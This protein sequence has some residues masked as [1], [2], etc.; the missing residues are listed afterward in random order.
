MRLI[1]NLILSIS[2]LTKIIYMKTLY[3]AFLFFGCYLISY[4]QASKLINP[5]KN[6]TL[7]AP[8]NYTGSEVSTN[9]EIDMTDVGAFLK[10]DLE[11][12][13]GETRYDLQTNGS[14]NNRFT[15]TSDG[16]MYAVWTMGFQETAFPDRGTGYNSFDGSDWGD[17]PTARLEQDA[18][19]GWPNYSRT[20]SGA[21]FIINHVFTDGEYRLHYLRRDSDTEDWTEGDV[22]TNTPSG[23]LWPNSTIGGA[24]GET[25]HVIAICTPETLGGIVYQGVE[26]HLLYYRSQD[27]GKTWDIVDGVLPGL[28][29]L[30]MVDL[31]RADAYDMDSNGD[32]ISMVLL[33]HW[34][35]VILVKSTD[36]GD[37]WTKTIV[38]DFPVD[39]YIT[40]TGY[41]LES[42]P[43]DSLTYPAIGSMFTSDGTGSVLVDNEGMSHVF[44]G[45]MYVTDA[46]TFDGTWSY[47]PGTTGIAYWNETFPSDSTAFIANVDDAN[48]NGVI[49]LNGELAPYGNA[50]LTSHTSPG[51]DAD[52]NIYLAYTAVVEGDEYIDPQDGQQ[53]RQTYLT[54]SLDGGETWSF[55]P[56]NIINAET[57]GDEAVARLT[58]AV[59]PHMAKLVDDQI[60]IMYQADF[61]PGLSIAGDGDPYAENIIKYVAIDVDDLIVSNNEVAFENDVQLVPNPASGFTRLIID[62]PLKDKSVVMLYNATGQLVWSQKLLTNTKVVEIPLAEIAKGIHYVKLNVGNQSVTKKLVKM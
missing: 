47:W 21:E 13:I 57:V 7:Q 6:Y 29:S 52:G 5:N 60:H 10:A 50:G 11:I 1:H 22:P 44:F 14:I 24:N 31:G 8:P 30:S 59:F 40:D 23:T 27:A 45:R 32:D 38:N 33:D 26:A 39:S 56:Y 42:V 48:A 15:R 4:G 53:Y 19:T 36:N 16:E 43:Y 2:I 34:N 37:T 61:R 41:D 55:P 3:T 54:R 18:R 25:I 35:D 62:S 49:D 28:D 9:T 17:I 46:D 58:E 51:I 12:N 20:E